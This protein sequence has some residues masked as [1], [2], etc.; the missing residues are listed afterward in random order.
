[1]PLRR[2]R[3]ALLAAAVLIGPGPA[4]AH[5]ILVSST[6]RVS[7]TVPPGPVSIEFRFNSRIDRARS[8]MSLIRPDRSQSVLPLVPETTEDVL[9][10][11]ADL[12]PGA[13]TVRWQVLAV[14]GHITRGDVPFTVTDH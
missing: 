14:D 3:T 6:P 10:A 11:R 4:L 8:R 7:G 1:M 5:A 13:Y 12:T 2:T 9:A